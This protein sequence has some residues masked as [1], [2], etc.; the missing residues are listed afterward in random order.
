LLYRIV[1]DLSGNATQNPPLK[2]ASGKKA[3]TYDD[4]IK[5][6]TKHFETILNC[7]EPTILHDFGSDKDSM[8]L[9]LD[10]NLEYVFRRQG[11]KC[12]KKIEKWK[13]SRY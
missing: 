3:K 8:T 13:I 1:K 11:E 12:H 7:P 5:R 9:H 6:W 10:I 2:M 4:Q